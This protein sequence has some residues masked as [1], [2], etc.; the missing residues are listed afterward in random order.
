MGFIFVTG[1]FRLADVIINAI[2]NQFRYDEI[3]NS[4]YSRSLVYMPSTMLSD[5]RHR[6]I[7]VFA[8]ITSPDCRTTPQHI[9]PYSLASTSHSVVFPIPL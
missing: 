1:S 2:A 4:N 6:R 7:A 9:K 8:H 5:D 3:D